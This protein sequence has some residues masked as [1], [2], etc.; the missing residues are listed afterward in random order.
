MKSKYEKIKEQ[1]ILTK[2]ET[3][4]EGIP[5]EFNKY[6]SYC[7]KLKFPEK[8]DYTYCRNLFKTLFHAQGFVYD[9]DFDWN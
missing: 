9:Y 1:K 3:L 7:W 8:P 2:V 4:C 5:E 6:S